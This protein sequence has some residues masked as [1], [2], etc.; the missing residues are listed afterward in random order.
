MP[1]VNA[2]E[3]EAAIQAAAEAVK[4]GGAIKV[5]AREHGV[6]YTT[7]HDRINGK[8]KPVERAVKHELPPQALQPIVAD[9]LRETP[10]GN[11]IPVFIRDY[12]D[13][14][15]HRIY[16][17]GDLHI[18]AKS[19]AEPALD[20]WFDYILGAQHTSMLNTGDNTNCA[21]KDSVSDVYQERL[22]VQEARRL[23][24]RK[25]APLADAGL[26]D[27]IIDGNHEMRV[28]RHTGD[29]PNAQVAD[30]LGLNYAMSACI[31][32]Y[33][34]GDQSYDCYLRHGKGGGGTYGAAVNNLA[35][36]EAIIDADFYVSGHTHTQVAFPKNV[37]VPNG[38]GGFRRKKR[39]FVCSGSFLSYED[40]AAEAGYAPAHI[41]APRIYL[42]GARH[43]LHASV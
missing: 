19:F 36:Q 16:P 34:V 14:A 3:R 12:R 23:Q 13:Q 32:R 35:K 26:I 37:F 28:Y 38:N 9:G 39:L 40:Y 31:V 8:T 15:S 4:A 17:I 22:T 30:A 33:L 29:S 20:E 21:L 27:A 41:G 7:L 11:E 2:P 1:K 42:D 10:E 18:G 5:A 25:F 24:T 6:P 43:D